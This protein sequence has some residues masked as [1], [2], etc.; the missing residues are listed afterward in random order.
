MSMRSAPIGLGTCGL[1]VCC[2]QQR[3]TL[4]TLR[5]KD[6]STL[7]VVE[8]DRKWWWQEAVGTNTL[9]RLICE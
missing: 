4:R 3:R 9:R 2:V 8:C 6:A 7:L 1:G 5:T